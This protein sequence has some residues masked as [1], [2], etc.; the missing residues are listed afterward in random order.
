MVHKYTMVYS[1]SR[2]YRAKKMTK[3]LLYATTAKDLANTMLKKI[4]EK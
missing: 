4:N 1:F 3:F 2:Y